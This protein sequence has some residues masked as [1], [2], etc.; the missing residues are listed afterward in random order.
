MPISENGR[1]LQPSSHSFFWNHRFFTWRGYYGPIVVLPF[2]IIPLCAGIGI[3]RKRVWSAYGFAIFILA[4]LLLIPVIVLRPGLWTGAHSSNCFH[5]MIGSLLLGPCYLCCRDALAASGAARGKA[6]P[7]IVVT[8]LTT[9]PF[10]FVQIKVRNSGVRLRKTRCCQATAF[11]LR[12][13]RIRHLSGA[14]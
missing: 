4:Q 1:E 9:V 11:W 2:A 12:S 13:F 5:I 8:A 14:K 7:W 10:F 3:L 6:F